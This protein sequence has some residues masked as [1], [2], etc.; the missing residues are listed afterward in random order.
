MS[1]AIIGSATSRGRPVT[2]I[3]SNSP[4]RPRCARISATTRCSRAFGSSG[5][6]AGPKTKRFTFS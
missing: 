3:T 4:M 2:R 6:A 5:G 1:R